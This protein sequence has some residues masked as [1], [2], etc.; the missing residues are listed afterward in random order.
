MASSWD[1]G[2]MACIM[3]SMDAPYSSEPQSFT[4]SM[5]SATASVVK[6]RSVM[7]KNDVEINIHSKST[8]A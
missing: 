6:V 1:G 4:S 2:M 5:T 7:E 8:V 3:S